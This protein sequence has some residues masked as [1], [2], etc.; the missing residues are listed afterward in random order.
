M[1][2]RGDCKATA[3]IYAVRMTLPGTDQISDAVAVSLC[4]CAGESL[5]VL[6]PFHRAAG[7]V[8]YG[9]A[10]AFFDANNMFHR[11]H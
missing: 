5:M 7:S 10:F 6:H 8:N 3:I 11:L 9:S 4:H 1:A 2:Q